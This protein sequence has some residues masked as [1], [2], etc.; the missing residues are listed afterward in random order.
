MEDS[1]EHLQSENGGGTA[2]STMSSLRQDAIVV[3]D[4][5]RQA[6][7]PQDR[8]RQ[9][10]VT[11]INRGPSRGNPPQEQALAR[12]HAPRHYPLPSNNVVTGRPL[13]Q[14]SRKINTC[15]GSQQLMAQDVPAQPGELLI[16]RAY[17]R[18]SR[19]SRP[20]LLIR[21][22]GLLRTNS[23]QRE[24]G[25]ERRLRATYLALIPAPCTTCP[26]FSTSATM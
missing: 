23:C 26:T 12:V 4:R 10:P 19:R 11:W 18:N 22:P 3:H 13:A 5:L 24:A 1:G 21:R 14:E 20:T 2:R 8:L 15:C 7:D 6:S 25:G 17:P 16:Q 9:D